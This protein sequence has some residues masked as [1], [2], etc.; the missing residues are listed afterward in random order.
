M[1]SAKTDRRRRV[2]PLVA[3]VVQPVAKRL[4]RME[5]LLIEMRHEQD[6]QLKRSI[7]LEEQLDTLTEHVK[8][9]STNI[10]RM[11]IRKE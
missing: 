7:A 9:N 4:S 8:V 6:V 1:P 3:A 10:R 11:S 2:P 5:A